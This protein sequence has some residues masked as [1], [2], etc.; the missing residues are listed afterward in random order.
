[1]NEEQIKELTAQL[2]TEFEKS[3]DTYMESKLADS[4]GEKAAA[5]VKKAVEKMRIDS[6]LSG[7]D[8]TGLSSDDKTDFANTVKEVASGT[9]R[10]KAASMISEVDSMGGYLLPKDVA[11][12]ILRISESVGIVMSQ[13]QKWSF[14]GN[15][16]GI[17]AYTGSV[18]TGE[19]LGVD[20]V[21]TNTAESIGLEQ[22]TI[23]KKKWQL[24]FALGNDLLQASPVQLADWL[25]ALAGEAVA[26]M[27]DKQALKGAGRPFVGITD[28]STTNSYT[29]VTGHNTIA[30]ID[31]TD[32]SAAVAKLPVSVRKGSAWYM[33]PTTWATIR[34]MKDGAGHYVLPQ[35]GA[36]SN[37]VLANNPTG[38]AV[39]PSGELLGYPVFETSHVFTPTSPTTD[40]AGEKAIVFGNMRGV[41]MSDGEMSVDTFKSGTFGGKEIGLS[42]QT[43]LVFKHRHGLVVSQPK[44]FVHVVMG[45]AS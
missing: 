33:D 25:L 9:Y 32:V 21:G 35:A 40:H 10:A 38:G 19:Y 18:L 24:P 16:L 12:A 17:P 43:A 13:A 44:C 15:E 20:A 41:S 4:L 42:D 1:M 26:N 2:T 39:V 30:E 8:I 14:N 36:V 28:L 22:E 29:L 27:I 45:A 31:L 23:V 5:E 6:A 11:A 37:G 7:K 34:A 3:V